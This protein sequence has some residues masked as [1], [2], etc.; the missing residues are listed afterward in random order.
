MNATPIARFDQAHLLSDL[1]LD[2]SRPVLTNLFVDF[3]RAQALRADALFILGDL[4]EVWVGDDDDAPLPATIA[5]HL[6]AVANSGVSVYFMHGNR[7]FLL[8]QAY[9]GLANMQL[10]AD[11]C[12][13]TLSGVETLLSHGDRYCISDQRYTA[14]RLQVRSPA[15]QTALL[16]Q[17]L[18]ARRALARQLRRES[19]G[20]QEAQRQAGIP[21][22]DVDEATILD[23]LGQLG[24]KRLIHGHTHRPA[25]HPLALPDGQSGER[26]VLSDWHGEEGEVLFIGKDGALERH[27]LR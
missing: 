9:A 16:A 2:E 12:I 17:P 11:P 7:D 19:M 22:A 26:I 20:S 23:E 14:F 6:R 3:L 13:V 24:L 25:I 10:L 21:W 5:G 8:G 4:F 1:H 15:W 27:R 18:E